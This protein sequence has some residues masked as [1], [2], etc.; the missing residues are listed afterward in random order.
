MKICF[1]NNNGMLF[2]YEFVD[3]GELQELDQRINQLRMGS[4]P[5]TWFTMDTLRDTCRSLRKALRI[6]KL[7]AFWGQD[8]DKNTT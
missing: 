8:L 6:E 5:Y 7:F 2:D 4:K 1:L 3:S